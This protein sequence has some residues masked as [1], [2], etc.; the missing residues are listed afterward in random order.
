VQSECIHQLQSHALALP[1]TEIS[2]QR[3]PAALHFI[4]TVPIE[5]KTMPIDRWRIDVGK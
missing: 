1:P 5:D 4:V 2:I 3:A